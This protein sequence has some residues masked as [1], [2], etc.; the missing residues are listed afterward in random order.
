[1]T[2]KDITNAELLKAISSGFTSVEERFQRIEERLDGMPTKE[3]LDN[4]EQRLSVKIDGVRNSLDSEI[5]RRTDEY[6]KLIKRITVLEQLHGIEPEERE[7]I[8]V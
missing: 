6:S 4:L 1:M 8:I 2:N 5:L 7:P 3:S